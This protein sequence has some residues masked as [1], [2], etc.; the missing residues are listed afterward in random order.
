[1]ADLF[2]IMGLGRFKN[3][4]T[5]SRE[6]VEKAVASVGDVHDW[7]AGKY[8]KTED[9]WE[10][11]KDD[12][13]GAKKMGD[14]SFSEQR[15]IAANLGTLDATVRAEFDAMLAEGLFEAVRTSDIDAIKLKILQGVDINVDS[16]SG[17]PVTRA[18]KR[19]EGPDFDVM[20]MLID[21]GADI[22]IRGGMWGKTPLHE[23][24]L[25]AGPEG[26]KMLL[27][28]GADPTIKDHADQT[29]LDILQAIKLEEGHILEKP[30]NESIRLLLAAEKRFSSRKTQEGDK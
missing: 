7:K 9:G 8:V 23:A 14:F 26:V 15:K 25:N 21:A 1:M 3:V 17:S 18:M 28:N 2:G 27:D 16:R 24:T 10:R 13:P 29:P 30:M 11:V 5:T 19:D 12:H 4:S 20:Q 22:N 6:Y